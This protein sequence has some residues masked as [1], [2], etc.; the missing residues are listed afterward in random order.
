[1]TSILIALLFVLLLISFSAFFSGSETALTAASKAK[2]HT[3]EQDGDWRAKIVNRLL[4]RSDRLIGALLLGNNL[5]NI[6]AS[7]IATKV[8]IDLFG[9]EGVAYATLTM[10]LLVLIF[11]EVLPKTYALHN[12]E[13]MALVISPVI[14]VVVTVFYPITELITRIVRGI[15]G[16]FGVKFDWAGVSS[17]EELKGA[18]ELHQ[19]LEEEAQDKV[20]HERNMLRSV[21]DLADLTVEEIMIHRRSVEMIDASLKPEEIIDQALSSP[22]TRL[23]IYQDDP[24]NIIGIIHVKPLMRQMRDLGSQADTIDILSL[25]S[26]PWFIPETTT[27]FQQLNAFRNRK[28]HF[29]IVVDEYGSLQGVVTLEDILEEI[30]GEIEDEHDVETN[31]VKK[32]KQGEY[33]VE[34]TATIRDLNRDFDWALPDEDYSTLAGLIIHESKTIPSEGQSFSFFGYRFDVIQR[35]RHQITSIKVI[36]PQETEEANND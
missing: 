18:I 15:L 26:E 11:A 19:S 20:R 36:P 32:D 21:L 33:I 16:V 3:L 24:D 23:P 22:Y 13:K 2:M 29:A 7:A 34:G 14:K 4:A 8:M 5:V 17:I 12:S 27:L 28:E 10:T 6:L 9:D 35:A 30:V 25:V 31:A 1:M